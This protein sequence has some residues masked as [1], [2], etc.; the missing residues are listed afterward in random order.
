M[1]VGFFDDQALRWQA[2][3]H[4][5]FDLARDEGSTIVRA[6][7]DWARVAPTRPHR[8]ANPFDPAYRLDDVNEFVRNAQMRGMQ[9]L[10]TIWGTP[11]WANGGNAPNV[12]PTN[13][14]DLRDFAHALAA[15]FSGRYKSFP[16]VRFF[17]VWNEPNSGLFLSP[18]FDAQG[19]PVAP[20]TYARLVAAAYAGIKS[21]SP[22]AFVAAGETAPRGH[23]RHVSGLHDA[24]S[25]LTF[26]RLVAK[27]AP[28]LPFDAWAHHPYPLNDLT[29]PGAAQPRR[30]VGLGELSQLTSSLDS[31]FHRRQVRLWVTEFA[32]RTRPQV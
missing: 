3:R 25:P 15:R 28:H 21:A 30:D 31:W 10:L 22:G 13:V 27:A 14:R 12:A 24:E 6:L 26:A 11:T 19:S 2:S 29:Q 16:F 8:P 4:V 18:Q 9:V 17:S 32:Y 23:D 7:V 5:N 1:Y 20:A